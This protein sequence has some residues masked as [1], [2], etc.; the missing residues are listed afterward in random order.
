MSI[1]P[2][3]TIQNKV[4]NKMLAGPNHMILSWARKCNTKSI[5]NNVDLIVW[6]KL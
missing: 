5:V 1:G 2:N 4:N 6:N 3:E